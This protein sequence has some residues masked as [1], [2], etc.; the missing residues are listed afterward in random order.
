MVPELG[1][2][3]GPANHCL[4][5][6]WEVARSCQGAARPLE[7]SGQETGGGLLVG[8]RRKKRER[9]HV[10]LY[11]ITW[12]PTAFAVVAARDSGVGKYG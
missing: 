12:A 6:I 3:Q 8:H 7:V 1:D 9:L 2:L 11:I 5:G 10:N 4:F